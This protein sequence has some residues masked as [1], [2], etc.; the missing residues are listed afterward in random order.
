VLYLALLLAICVLWRPTHNNTRY[1]YA[2]VRGDGDELADE[3]G[4]ELPVANAVQ[5]ANATAD[6]DANNN[7][8]NSSSNIGGV[9]SSL[10]NAS[11]VAP[12]IGL[13]SPLPTAGTVGG[14]RI[15]KMN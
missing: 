9:A 11:G 3:K 1:A 6:S 2:D 4:G 12:N 14:E 7:N 10:S 5:R 8:N 15:G 13:E